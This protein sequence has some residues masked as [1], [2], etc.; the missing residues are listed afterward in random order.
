MKRTVFLMVCLGLCFSCRRSKAV[1][2]ISAS[3]TIEAT[4]IR[5]SFNLGGR[6]S[7]VFLEEGSRVAAGEPVAMLDTSFLK[8]QLKQVEAGVK[9]AE[10][11]LQLLIK[12]ARSEDI[13]QVQESLKQ[14][15]TGLKLAREDFARIRSLFEK[16][17]ATTKQRDDAEARHIIALA[18][19]QT[20][21]EALKKVSQLARPEEIRAA[22]ARLDQAQAAVE[23]LQ[24]SIADCTLTASVD[25]ILTNRA[26]EPGEFAAPG[27][28]V[29][30]LSN[31]DRVHLMIYI[32]ETE[33]GRLR[34]GDEAEVSIDSFPDRVFPGKV[35]FISPRAEFT[36]KNIQTREERVKLVFGV[37]VEVEN[38]DHLLKPGL[39]A[40]ALLKVKPV[41]A[42]M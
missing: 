29:A 20:A 21:Q 19:Y 23:L 13:R 2:E 22:E 5:L 26:V 35:V 34:L 30:T 14:A 28:T 15:E 42:Q 10:A 33:L 24:K 37:K 11:Q 39:P 9:L 36:P 27:A 8:I 7:K 12:G 16:G 3:G 41:S 18:Q 4:E 25:G 38:K 6:V 32:K 31:L 17:T 40:D 1:P